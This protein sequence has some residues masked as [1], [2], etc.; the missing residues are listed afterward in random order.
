MPISLLEKSWKSDADKY[1]FVMRLCLRETVRFHSIKSIK[2][3]YTIGKFF[4]DRLMIFMIS[5]TVKILNELYK[6][7]DTVP[8]IQMNLT[9][10]Q[11]LTTAQC[12]PPEKPTPSE[13]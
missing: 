9:C 12:S 7:A 6:I 11:K 3:I 2:P 4:L 1:P 13:F 8:I 10:V 5:D